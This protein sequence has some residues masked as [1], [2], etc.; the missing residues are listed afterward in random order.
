MKERG[1]FGPARLSLDP[2]LHAEG[3]DR[4]II[5]DLVDPGLVGAVENIVGRIEDIPALA[6]NADLR[7]D[8]QIGVEIHHA[9]LPAEATHRA[10]V[11]RDVRPFRAETGVDPPDL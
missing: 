5:F 7:G 10:A 2:S 8:L 3:P 4:A 1:S 11:G 6:E 9:A